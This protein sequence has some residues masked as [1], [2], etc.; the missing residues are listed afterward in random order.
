MRRLTLLPAV[1][2]LSLALAAC[3]GTKS[4][5]PEAT[6]PDNGG[7]NTVF[8][9]ST[10]GDPKPPDPAATPRA[11]PTVAPAKGLSVE[12]VQFK[13]NDNGSVTFTAQVLNL[14]SEESR[15]QKVVVELYDASGQ[16]VAQ[17]SFTEPALPILKPGEGASWQGQRAN[18]AG[19]WTEV[20]ASAV[21][22]PVSASR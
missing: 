14:G 12:N 1:L 15:V 13:K 7:L 8:S 22:G 3:G 2:L 9:L 11:E 19:D 17:V 16:R 6:T 10:T 20:R 5:T 21:A 4:A 18:L